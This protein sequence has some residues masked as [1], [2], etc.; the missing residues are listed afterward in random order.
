MDDVNIKGPPTCYETIEDRWYTSMAFSDPPNRSHPVICVSGLDGWFYE[1]LAENL[2]IHWLVWEHIHNVNRVLQQVN[3]AG[4]MFS[5][6]K[7]E[8]CIP[9][10]VTIG[11][12][13]TYEGCY[14]EDSKVQKIQD[15]PDC[16]SL[17][18][19]Q[20][21]L[22]V[23]SMVWIWVKDFAKWARPL[24]VLT[25]KD[26][27]FVWGPEQKASM[28]DLKLVVVST[29]CLWPINYHCDWW[30]ILAMDSSCIVTGG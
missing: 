20:G 15:W 14:P 28:E 25:R 27:E 24:V 12:K 8:I 1:V 5:G 21:F 29:P 22:G 10:V 11:H 13:C 19:V 2:A 3:K 7:M 17:T 4:G 18:E 9:E 30:V 16:T 23:C 26:T 6:W